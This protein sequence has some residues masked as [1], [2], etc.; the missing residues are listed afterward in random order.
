[1][2]ITREEFLGQFYYHLLSI[3]DSPSKRSIAANNFQSSDDK[4]RFMYTERFGITHWREEHALT[5]TAAVAEALT[6]TLESY[7]SEP[8]EELYN[9]QEE[10]RNKSIRELANPINSANP[11]AVL[12]VKIRPL[13]AVRAKDEA[14]QLSNYALLGGGILALGVLGAAA[15]LNTNPPKP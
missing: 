6:K 11:L 2:A 3:L 14:S 13:A 12:R 10:I 4:K 1:M 5:L 15:L 8:P 7:L 9:Y